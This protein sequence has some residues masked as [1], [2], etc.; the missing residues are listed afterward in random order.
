MAAD[1]DVGI[2]D[3]TLMEMGVTWRFKQSHGLIYDEDFRQYQMELRQAI[4]RAG[5]C[6]ILTLDDHQALFGQPIFLQP[7]RFR[8]WH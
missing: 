4:S 3:E 1:S 7:S 6:A 2:L 5:G 8:I